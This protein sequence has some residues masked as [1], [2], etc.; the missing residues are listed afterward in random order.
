MISILKKKYL[1]VLQHPD[2]DDF[3]SSEKQIKETLFAIS[4]ISMQTIWL[5]PNVDAGSDIFSKELRKFRENKNQI[6]YTSL[7]ICPPKFM[8]I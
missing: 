7:K 3:A 5:W 2:T 1:V 4:Q 8:L 6:I